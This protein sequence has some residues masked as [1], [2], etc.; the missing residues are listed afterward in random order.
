MNHLITST[1][2]QFHREEH[3]S[4]RDADINYQN[5]LIWF[6]VASIE[7]SRWKKSTIMQNLISS[8]RQ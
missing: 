3:P 5:D 4:I 1:Q 7:I 2:L 6:E 8:D